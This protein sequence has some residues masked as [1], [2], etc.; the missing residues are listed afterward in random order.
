MR[1][2][3]RR[4]LESLHEPSTEIAGVM[5]PSPKNSAAPKIAERD[6]RAAAATRLRCTRGQRHDAAV[7]AVV[8]AHD[9]AAYLIETTIIS[10]QKIS[11]TTP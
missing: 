9:E 11:E 7:T 4:D 6:E 2:R 1:E 10:A 3:G 8:R 5:T